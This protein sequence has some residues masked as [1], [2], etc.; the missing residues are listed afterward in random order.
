MKMTTK[1]LAFGLSVLIAA[2]L[3][4]V[5]E[6]HW[7]SKEDQVRKVNAAKRGVSSMVFR[8]L[9]QRVDAHLKEHG[10]M[11]SSLFD[12]VCDDFEL[13]QRV[14]SREFAAEEF[15]EPMANRHLEFVR[16]SHYW[17]EQLSDDAVLISERRNLRSDGRTLFCIVSKGA[18]GITNVIDYWERNL[19]P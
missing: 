4:L 3:L 10:E 7:L 19:S 13:L 6:N 14:A 1:K 18:E 17:L 15:H 8:Q 11:P 12:L 2:V 5:V 9:T 16:A